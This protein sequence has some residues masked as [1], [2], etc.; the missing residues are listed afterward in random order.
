LQ[1]G[2]KCTHECRL[3]KMREKSVAGWLVKMREK[4]VAGLVKMRG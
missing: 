2:E 1:A 3:V 4:S